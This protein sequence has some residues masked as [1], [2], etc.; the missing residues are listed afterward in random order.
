MLW[1][2]LTCTAMRETEAYFWQVKL[3]KLCMSRQKKH[4][5]TV[6]QTEIEHSAL[7]MCKQGYRVMMSGLET[8]NYAK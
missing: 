1:S 3:G 4:Q 8:P 5:F 2:M 7:C 6:D